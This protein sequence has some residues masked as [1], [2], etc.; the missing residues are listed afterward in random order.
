MLLLW[1][2][3]FGENGPGVASPAYREVKRIALLL[4]QHAGL[5]WLLVPHCQPVSGTLEKPA[6]TAGRHAWVHL[7]CS[8]M[9]HCD[10]FKGHNPDDSGSCTVYTPHLGIDCQAECFGFGC[11]S[12]QEG[13]QRSEAVIL[14][15][16]SKSLPSS[17]W[18]KLSP[19]TMGWV[20]GKRPCSVTSGVPRFVFDTPKSVPNKG[21]PAQCLWNQ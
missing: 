20:Q 11:S 12:P 16:T 18:S 2:L 8:A 4:S 19:E 14:T 1:P 5:L 7:W 17:G 10:H 3:E 9:W 15:W 21:S 13:A 6:G